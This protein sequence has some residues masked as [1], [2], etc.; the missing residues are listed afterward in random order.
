MT[1]FTSVA[2]ALAYHKSLLRQW[3]ACGRKIF[4]IYRMTAGE[5]GDFQSADTN[6]N[7]EA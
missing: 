2:I 6:V 1:M 7:R 3:K 4:R 5:C